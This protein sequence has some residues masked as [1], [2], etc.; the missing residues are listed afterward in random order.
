[1]SFFKSFSLVFLVFEPITN[2]IVHQLSR[3][4]SKVTI[5]YYKI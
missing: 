3:M 4:D 1:M 2:I 5:L